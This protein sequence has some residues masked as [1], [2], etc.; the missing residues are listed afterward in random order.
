MRKISTGQRV[1]PIG[2]VFFLVGAGSQ[3][4]SLVETA[5]NNDSE[6]LRSLVEQGADVNA[7]WGDGTTALHW[8]SYW[9]DVESSDLLIRAGADANATTDLGV[10]PL[11]PA[12]LNGSPAMVRRL[13]RAGANPNAS[14]LLG[15]TLVMTAARSGNPEVVE[16]LFAAGAD[17]NAQPMHRETTPCLFDPSQTCAVQAGGQTALMWAVAQKH[18]DVVAVLLAYGSDVHARSQVYSVMHAAGYP[19]SVPENKRAF[20]VGGDTPLTFAARVGDLASAELLAAAGADVNDADAFMSAVALAAYWDHVDMVK[21]L[22]EEGADPNSAA[23]ELSP[24]HLAILNRNEELVATLLA[25]GADPN[26]PLRAWTHNHRGSRDR[27]IHPAMVGATPTWMAA[28]FGT[29]NMIRLLVE[30]GAD[31]QVMHNSA[32]YD[33][34]LGS[35]AGELAGIDTPRVTQNTTSLMAAFG[36][37]TVLRLG[38]GPQ[39]V[40]GPGGE[41]WP[42]RPAGQREAEVLEIVKLLVEVGVDVN[43]VNVFDRTCDVPWEVAPGQVRACVDVARPDDDHLGQFSPPR[44][45]LEAATRLQFDAV[46]QFLLANGATPDVPPQ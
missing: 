23:S 3:D 41:R 25:H 11:W 29:A 4:L 2:L 33:M 37:T 7:A 8:V 42:E 14:L 36:G 18:A 16:L 31:P 13:L 34:S 24:L 19:A 45:A 44:T 27:Y 26:A 17:V 35:L 9:D 12:S 39:E 32:Y 21:F 20:P 1:I 22:L 10:T 40:G 43:A 30:H 15:E 5:R 6:R 38:D 46:V 28:R